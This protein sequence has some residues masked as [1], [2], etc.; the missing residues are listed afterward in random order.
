MVLDLLPH[1]EPR[2]LLSLR[3]KMVRAARRAAQLYPTSPATRAEL[4]RASAEIGMH[5][6]AVTEAEMA[7]RLDGLTPHLD[8]KLP[9]PVARELKAKIPEW[10]ALR[11]NPP[12]PPAKNQDVP[13]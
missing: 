5:G 12:K 1:P 8:K 9:E 7:L 6:D 3:S 11:D 2:D 4:A 10:A 13:K